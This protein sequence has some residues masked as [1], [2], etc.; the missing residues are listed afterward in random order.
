MIKI[1]PSG[2][3]DAGRGVFATQRIAKDTHVTN[4]G[5]VVWDMRKYFLAEASGDLRVHYALEMPKG[6]GIILVPE[7]PQSESLDCVGHVLND[8][9]ALTL[10]TEEYEFELQVKEYIELSPRRANVVVQESGNVVT[11]RDVDAGEELFFSY[12]V[13]YWVSRIVSLLFWD[14]RASKSSRS[15]ARKMV[16]KAREMSATLGFS[17]CISELPPDVACSRG[18]LVALDTGARIEDDQ[19]VG[20]GL[21]LFGRDP[22]VVRLPKSGLR[23][24]ILVAL[25]RL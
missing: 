16:L 24:L 22:A 1:A 11:L 13:S 15:A 2:L 18:E 10:A 25:A 4:F 6:S 8:A 19:L 20:I 9:S 3:P 5:G 21:A 23:K 14:S 17:L 7:D 12:G